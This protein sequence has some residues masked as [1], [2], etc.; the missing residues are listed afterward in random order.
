MNTGSV[1]KQ[2]GFAMGTLAGSGHKGATEDVMQILEDIRKLELA[3]NCVRDKRARRKPIISFGHLGYRI[4]HPR[5][6]YLKNEVANVSKE[7]GAP[8]WF[9]IL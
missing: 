9:E 1:D 2:K 6:C 5:G 4:E 3:R 7:L 8:R